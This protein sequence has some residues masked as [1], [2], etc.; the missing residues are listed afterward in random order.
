[1]VTI[2]SNS[3]AAYRSWLGCAWLEAIEAPVNTNYKGDW[4]R[5]VVNNTEAEVVLTEARF[6]QPLFHIADQITDVKHCVVF[7]SLDS[8]PRSLRF[9][10]LSEAEF[11]E[12]AMVRERAEPEP[13]GL[14][15][16]G[17]LAQMILDQPPRA[18]DADNPI[19]TVVMAPVIPAAGGGI[20][21]A[22]LI[23]FLVPRMPR[24]AGLPA[25]I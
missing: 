1:M 11:L 19:R 22:E 10:V 18:D 17:P 16:L 5:H 2:F 6:S 25:R 9:N 4:L 12:G 13:N 21:P 24:F 14:V 23:E 20:R 3:F 15:L 8:V 7:G